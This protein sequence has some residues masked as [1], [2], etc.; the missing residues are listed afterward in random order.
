MSMVVVVVMEDEE[1]GGTETLPLEEDKERI[2]PH[3][4][5]QVRGG[6]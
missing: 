3:H 2:H 1:E 4:N 5:G 6:V